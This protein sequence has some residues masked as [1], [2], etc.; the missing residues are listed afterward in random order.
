MGADDAAARASIDVPEVSLPEHWWDNVEPLKRL[1]SSCES[2]GEHAAE[3]CPGNGG[4]PIGAESIPSY[5]RLQSSCESIDEDARDATEIR[6]EIPSIH[7][8]S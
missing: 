6:A 2:I 7:I 1:Q 8:A 3:G 4:A 5:K